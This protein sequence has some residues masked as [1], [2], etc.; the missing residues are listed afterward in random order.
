[1]PFDYTSGN[2]DNLVGGVPARMQ[3]I[4]GPFYDLRAY[5]NS[6]PSGGGG[7]GGGGV[8]VSGQVSEVGQPNQLRAGRQL[9]ASDFT[10][11][12]LSAPR[13]LWNL[14]DLTDASG[15]ARALTNKGGVP[16]AVGINGNAAT[17]AQFIGSTGQA[18]Y[19]ADTGAAD[20]FRITTGSWGCWFRVAKRAVEQILLTKWRISTALRSWLLEVTTANAAQAIVSID[21]TAQ[22]SAAGVTDVIDDRWHFAVATFDAAVL[23]LYVD[24]ALESQT[25]VAGTLFASTAP[26][27]IGAYDADATTA[28]GA[29]FSGRVDEAFVTA[30]VLSD[31]QVRLLYAARLTH[32]LGATPKTVSLNVRRARKGAALVATDFVTAPLRLYNF[33]AGVWTDQ[34]SNNVSVAPAGGGAAYQAI[35]ADGVQGGSYWITAT[36]WMATDAGL[37]TA[38]LARSYGCWFKTIATAATG[39]IMSWGGATADNLNSNAGGTLIAWNGGDSISG[40]FIADGQW[41]S[42]VIVEDNAAA[43][44]VKRKLYLDGRLVG[45]ST[46]LNSIVAGGANR[47]RIG[48]FADGTSPFTGQIDT[49]FVTGYA[50]STDEVLRLY[51]KGAQPLVASPKNAGDHVE[52]FDSG[53]LLFIGDTLESQHSIDLTVS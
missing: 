49:A 11:L 6:L 37:P 7:G 33:T 21:G 15:N 17:A 48:S 2:P 38:L 40:P 52:G 3:D 10:A 50:M 41:H 4:Q 14:S 23:R 46:V 39:T 42:A 5:L 9:A 22:A 31:D 25:A 29:P 26:V 30:D 13:G 34:G 24:G 51:A 44:G 36:G 8:T 53:S 27:N 43:D 47:F 16:F 32:T 18:L 20:P 12:G 28:A 35:G 1:M 19:I 45:G